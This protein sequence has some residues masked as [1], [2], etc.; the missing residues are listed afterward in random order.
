MCSEIDVDVDM[1]IL[2]SDIF[3]GGSGGSGCCCTCGDGEL[4]SEEG[5]PDDVIGT[6]DAL[7]VICVK[8]SESL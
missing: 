2:D 7:V 4:A 8:S 3:D 5:D 1:A 6:K